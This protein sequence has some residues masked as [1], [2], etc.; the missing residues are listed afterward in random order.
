MTGTFESLAIAYSVLAASS[1]VNASDA[2]FAGCPPSV[3]A[4]TQYPYSFHARQRRAFA[5]TAALAQRPP[6]SPT[7]NAFHGSSWS[8]SPRELGVAV[9]SNLASS[10]DNHAVSAFG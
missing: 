4:N 10:D 9:K 7:T 2:L 6:A 5:S 1:S 3:Q 8:R